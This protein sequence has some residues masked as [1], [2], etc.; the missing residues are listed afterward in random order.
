MI[1]EQIYF[2]FIPHYSE[3]L[4][5]NYNFIVKLFHSVLLQLILNFSN[6]NSIFIVNLRHFCYCNKLHF[7]HS[8]FLVI[9]I[10]KLK[11]FL[12]DSGYISLIYLMNFLFND[13]QELRLFQVLES[14]FMLLFFL[15]YAS[16]LLNCYLG[17]L[18]FKLFR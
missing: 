8:I 5:I 10:L 17:I 7:F 11:C 18:N 14:N 2:H 12:F 13:Y 1:L 16:V 9:F 4:L 3:I 15:E 6:L